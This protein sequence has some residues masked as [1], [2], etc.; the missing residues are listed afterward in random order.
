MPFYFPFPR[1]PYLYRNPYYFNKYSNNSSKKHIDNVTKNASSDFSNSNS[2]VIDHEEI[3]SNS[4]SKNRIMNSNN[5]FSN[6][7]SFLPSSIGPLCFN[8]K[9]LDDLDEPLFEMFGINL[10]LDDII[11]VCVL[12]FLYQEGV[13]DDMLYIGLFLLLIS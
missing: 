13:K 6:I 11:I 7:F 12:I 3:N 10:Y 8:P 9:A 2:K 5:A 4:A 1:F